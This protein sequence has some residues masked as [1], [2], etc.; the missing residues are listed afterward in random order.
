MSNSENGFLGGLVLL[1]LVLLPTKRIAIE[2][3]LVLQIFQRTTKDRNMSCGR[4][5]EGAI[6]V[7]I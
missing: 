3:N 1:F 5:G 4:G 6:G 2:Y 7:Q